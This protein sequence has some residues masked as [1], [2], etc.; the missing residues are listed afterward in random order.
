MKTQL[1]KNGIERNTKT[2]TTYNKSKTIH[3][4][5][6]TKKRYQPIIAKRKGK[7]PNPLLKN[8]YMRIT[9]KK[10][11]TTTQAKDKRKEYHKNYYK[12]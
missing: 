5:K 7:N 2:A 4:P 6:P 12:K 8:I 11:Y 9:G 10:R 1:H 3:D